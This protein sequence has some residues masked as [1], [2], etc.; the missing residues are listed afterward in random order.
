MKIF[1]ENFTK[2]T[3]K[4]FTTAQTEYEKQLKHIFREILAINKQTEIYLLGFYNPFNQ[5]FKEIKELDLIVERWNDVGKK[6]ANQHASITFIPIKDLFDHPQSK[7]FSE[8][9]F[10]PNKSGYERIAERVLHYLNIEGR[11]S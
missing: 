9:H 5:Y 6:I 4:Q 3:L 11:A 8:D 1:K 7:L 2:L 10:H